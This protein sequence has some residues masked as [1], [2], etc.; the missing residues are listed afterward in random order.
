M[1]IEGQ[2]QNVVAGDAV[3]IPPG[4]IHQITNSGSVALRLLCCCSPPYEDDD[5]IL[6]ES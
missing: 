4:Q 3:S 5:T 2:T 6:I 1:T